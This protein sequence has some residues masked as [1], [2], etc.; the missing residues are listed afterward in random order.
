MSTATLLPDAAAIA[1]PI[2]RRPRLFSRSNPVLEA[3]ATGDSTHALLARICMRTAF[4][5]CKLSGRSPLLLAPRLPQKDESSTVRNFQ[6]REEKLFCPVHC[7]IW[8]D[9]DHCA[10]R[11]LTRISRGSSSGGTPAHCQ[12]ASTNSQSRDN[13]WAII[14]KRWRARRMNFAVAKRPGCDHRSNS[15]LAAQKAS[16]VRSTVI[17]RNPGWHANGDFSPFKPCMKGG[18]WSFGSIRKAGKHSHV[19]QWYMN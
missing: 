1:T 2:N 11:G 16:L 5:M 17:R 14:A 7:G 6:E 8:G 10:D 18:G 19:C 15:G 12:N 4:G 13:T 3:Q 9:S